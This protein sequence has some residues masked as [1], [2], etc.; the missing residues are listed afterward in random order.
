MIFLTAD[1]AA[2]EVPSYLIDLKI[3][4]GYVKEWE[5]TDS[6]KRYLNRTYGDTLVLSFS[7]QQFFLDR[8]VIEN[9]K[10]YLPQVQE[11]IASF[12]Q[13]FPEVSEV[14]TASTMNNTQFTEGVRYM[15]QN[16]Y[17]AKR[18]GDVLVNY[19]PGYIEFYAPTGTTHGSPYSYD[20]HVPLLF[21]GWN[22]KQGSTTDQIYITDLAPT[23]AMMLN[24]QFPNGCTGKPITAVTGK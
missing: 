5:L 6:L 19:L 18:S 15:M 2:V 10:L 22:V 4:S 17:N 9:K 7:N 16:G 23:L 8:K 21:Y 1:H 14:V 12:I 24:I 13:R 20:T 11:D 3:P